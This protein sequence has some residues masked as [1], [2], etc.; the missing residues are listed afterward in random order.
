MRRAKRVGRPQQ[1]ALKEEW[2][3]VLHDPDCSSVVGPAIMWCDCKGLPEAIAIPVRRSSGPPQLAQL[4][5]PD[6]A[7]KM[8]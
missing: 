3:G 6:R 1:W 4:D 8:A 7:V 5:Q 2:K